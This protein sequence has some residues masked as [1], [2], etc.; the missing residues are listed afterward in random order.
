MFI[1]IE[2]LLSLYLLYGAF[3]CYLHRLEKALEWNNNMASRTRMGIFLERK[4]SIRSQLYNLLLLNLLMWLGRFPKAPLSHFRFSHL[5]S[6]FHSPIYS[7]SYRRLFLIHKFILFDLMLLTLCFVLFLV[8]FV[9][10]KGGKGRVKLF[11][12]RTE[13][14]KPLLML[15]ACVSETFLSFLIFAVKTEKVGEQPVRTGS[16]YLIIIYII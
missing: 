15:V 3:Y 16:G 9:T 8:H 14:T 11:L 12:L 13:S 5:F 6:I 1:R 10:Q 4:G 7:Y 2:L